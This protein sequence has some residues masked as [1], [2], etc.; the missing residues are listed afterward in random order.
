DAPFWFDWIYLLSYAGAGLLIGL[1][2]LR[3][4]FVWLHSWL[5]RVWAEV[6]LLVILGLTGFGIYLGRF[7]RWNTW[8]IVAQPFAFLTDLADLVFNPLDHPRMLAY[9]FGVTFMLGISWFAFR[10]APLI[11]HQPRIPSSER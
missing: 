10:L 6:C 11:M 1:V 9:S 8:D 3:H 4:V 7:P 2:S 5:G